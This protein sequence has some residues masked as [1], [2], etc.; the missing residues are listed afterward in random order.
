MAAVDAQKQHFSV[1]IWSYKTTFK[2]HPKNNFQTATPKQLFLVRNNFQTRFRDE[3]ST[4]KQQRFWSCFETLFST[5]LT[6]RASVALQKQQ[7]KKKREKKR[8]KKSKKKS[9][10][11]LEKK[12]RKNVEKNSK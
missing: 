2:Q 3:E 6:G 10:K 7:R 11:N 1:S 8:G 9:E 5:S 12:K 4:F